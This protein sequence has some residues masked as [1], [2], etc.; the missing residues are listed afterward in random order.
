M[1][2]ILAAMLSASASAAPHIDPAFAQNITVYHV[3]PKSAGAIPVNMDTGNAPGDLF[4]DLFEVII[5]PLNCPYGPKSGH[6]C[7]NPEAS[8][9]L[10]VNKLTLEVDSRYS[11]YAKCNICID[12]NDG[13]GHA[14]P[15]GTY[16]CFCATGGY[17]GKDIPCNKTVGRENLVN[18]FGHYHHGGCKWGESKGQCYEQAV[19]SKLNGSTLPA[20]WYSSQ[21]MGACDLPGHTGDSCTWRTVSVDKVVARECH[22]KVFGDI[23]QATQPPACLDACG[24]QKTNTSSP[25]WVDCFYKAAVGPESGRPGGKPGGMSFA[26]LTEAWE[27]PFLPE[28]QG[29]CPAVKTRTPW[30]E[31]TPSVEEKM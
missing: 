5:Y 16:F 7:S 17:P 6:Q 15:S 24:S 4:F 11:G 26:E 31:R 23:V 8:G 3:N 13:R 12:G 10:N 18:S 9:D 14:C 29:G 19:F 28:D 2:R 20:Y 1:L 25:C 22:S 21:D 27:H 30:F